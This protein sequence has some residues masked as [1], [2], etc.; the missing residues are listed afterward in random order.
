M[1]SLADGFVTQICHISHS[2][3]HICQK[4]LGQLNKKGERSKSGCTHRQNQKSLQFCSHLK[5]ETIL[6]SYIDL[7]Q[8]RNQWKALVNMVKNLG[9]DKM[10]GI[11]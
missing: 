6:E 11:S 4:L 2:A 5:K 9:F 8:D 3:Q 1:V 7:A 10:L